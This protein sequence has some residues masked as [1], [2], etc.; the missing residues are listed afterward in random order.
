MDQTLLVKA[1]CRILDSLSSKGALPRA[2][3]W[4]RATDTDIWK[5]WILPGR[6]RRQ[7]RLLPTYREHR[8]EAPVEARRDRYC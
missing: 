2:A 4:V 5:L 1:G 8:V 3:L 6:I 7:A